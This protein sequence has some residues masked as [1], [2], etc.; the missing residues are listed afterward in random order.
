MKIKYWLVF[1]VVVCLLVSQNAFATVIFE[2]T[3]WIIGSDE[4]NYNFVA[5]EQPLLY[6]VYFTDLSEP[7]MSFDFLSLTLS[8]ATDT[9]FTLLEPSMTTFT[10]ELGATYFISVEGVAA[11][12][13]G[14]A[15]YGISIS[16]A[17]VP[18]PSTILLLG[19]GLAGLAWYGRKRKKM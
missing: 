9:I 14:G 10:A 1:S 12:P 3:G 6:E 18:E 19:S 11:E 16:T 2:T 4:N 13:F 8:S 7:P 5:D 15:L 17:P